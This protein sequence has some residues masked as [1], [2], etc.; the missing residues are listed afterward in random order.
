[1]FSVLFF[2]HLFEMCLFVEVANDNSILKLVIK[3]VLF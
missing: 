1:M 2:N 3:S